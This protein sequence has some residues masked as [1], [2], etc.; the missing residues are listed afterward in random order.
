MVGIEKSRVRVLQV[1]EVHGSGAYDLDLSGS[2]TE[3]KPGVFLQWSH[4]SSLPV[5]N[6]IDT[7]CGG[8]PTKRVT[9]KVTL[10]WNGSLLVDLANEP[11]WIFCVF[12]GRIREE[13][14]EDDDDGLD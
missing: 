2:N 11:G 4:E 9:V 14:E 13:E 12:R 3:F 7:G 10:W 5:S 8:V 1:G 6:T